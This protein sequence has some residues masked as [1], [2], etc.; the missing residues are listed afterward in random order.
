M[1]KSLK[2]KPTT[3][4]LADRLAIPDLPD[5]RQDRAVVAAWAKI[6]ELEAA[7]P[8][9]QASLPDLRA[10]Q[11]RLQQ[12]QGERNMLV[13]LGV[14]DMSPA[15]VAAAQQVA[16]ELSDVL[17]RVQAT[18]AAITTTGREI[19]AARAVYPQIEAQ[20]RK[21]VIAEAR[22]IYLRAVERFT[23]IIEQ[24]SAEQ[25]VLYALYGR[26]LAQFPAQYELIDG[27][28][29]VRALGVPAP[30]FE[31]LRPPQ[32]FQNDLGG[33]MRSTLYRWRLGLASVTGVEPAV[34]AQEAEQE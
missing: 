15:A 28:P 3:G 16:T 7:L 12:V 17:A 33:Q 27:E 20:A 8:T 10:R 26:I 25:E 32:A 23:A 13:L 5:W 4:A 21:R 34:T 19:E 2:K 14:A 24:A 30:L 9:Y 31:D 6:A 18:E 1:L 11:E 29:V 22:A